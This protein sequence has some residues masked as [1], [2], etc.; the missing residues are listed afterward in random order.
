MDAD[1]A[2]SSVETISIVCG[3]IAESNVNKTLHLHG[4]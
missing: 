4:L 1:S 3:E 2:S